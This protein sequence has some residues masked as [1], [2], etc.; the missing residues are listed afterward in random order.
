MEVSDSTL[1]LI[2]RPTASLRILMA[3]GGTGGHIFPALA[4]AQEL[5]ARALERQPQNP[6]CAILFLGAGREL[7]SRLIVGAGFP[8]HTIAA[9]GLKGIAGWR[10]LRNSLVL[11]RSALQTV[12]L[13]RAFQP[14]VVVGTGGYAAG[15]AMLEAALQ[16]VPTLLIEP[17]VVP[18]FTN[19]LLAPVVRVAA[20]GFEATARFYGASARLTGVPVRKAFLR[21]PSKQHVLPSTVLILGG[22]QGSKAINECVVQSLPLLSR[23]AG[24]LGIIHQTGERDYNAV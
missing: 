4:V 13:L 6:D 17:N 15:P 8:L 2:E 9:A 5:R 11:P 12:S 18:G 1:A 24:R 23:E 14:S 16:G 19:R 10:K 3:A 7:E 22:S 21:V 20:V